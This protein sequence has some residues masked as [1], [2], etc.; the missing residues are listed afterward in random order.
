MPTTLPPVLGPTLEIRAWTDE[1]VDAL[2]HDPRSPYVERFWLGV[3]G[4]SS[5]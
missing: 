3:L 4:P 2:G 1:V 5:I